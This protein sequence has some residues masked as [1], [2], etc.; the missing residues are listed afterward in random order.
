[1]AVADLAPAEAKDV[2][3]ATMKV[4][5][6]DPRLHE[7]LAEVRLE[8]GDAVGALKETDAA[9]AIDPSS[10]TAGRTALFAREI[11][12][13]RLDLAGRTALEAVRA[14]EAI[15]PKAAVARYPELL[16]KYPRSALVR[17]GRGAARRAAGDPGGID[18]LV[19]A[20]LVDPENIE[21]LAAAG[22][23]LVAVGRAEEAEPLL[24]GSSTARPWD[25][26]LGL[27]WVRALLLLGKPDAALEVAGQIAAR[28]PHDPGVQV[29]LGGVLLDNGKK[30]EAYRVVKAALL[31]APDPRLAAAFVRIAPLVGHGEEAAALLDQIVAQTGNA[32]L[33]EAARKL[34]DA[35]P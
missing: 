17:L 34:R 35:R 18:D 33:A 23:A 26:S 29:T 31:R 7:A 13:G 9:L 11:R 16:T 15:D 8:A 30:E 10:M 1:L 5:P 24:G 6:G 12:D 19:Q 21:A 27:G 4:V 2:L 3:S 25:P 20:V 22:L 14:Q 32:D 28:F